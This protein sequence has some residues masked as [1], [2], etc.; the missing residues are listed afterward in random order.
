MSADFSI[1]AGLP[2]S[3]EF[4][5]AAD[6]AAVSAGA[7]AGHREVKREASCA[8]RQYPLQQC[9]KGQTDMR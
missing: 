1:I 8:Q 2:V 5:I 6:V 4:K 7:P 9:N 3:Y